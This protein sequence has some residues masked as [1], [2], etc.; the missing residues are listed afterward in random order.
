VAG[1]VQVGWAAGKGFE[2]NLDPFLI[3]LLTLAV[4][5]AQFV[6]SDG[7]SNW[8]MGI[9]VGCRAWCHKPVCP[10]VWMGPS[11]ELVLAYLAWSPCC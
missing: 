9:Q 5:H 10:V 6:S 7:T 2:L 3:L 8:L 4:I 11:L 1:V